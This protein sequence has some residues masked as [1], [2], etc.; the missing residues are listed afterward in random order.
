MSEFQYPSEGTRLAQV[1]RTP[2]PRPCPAVPLLYTTCLPI[3][4]LDQSEGAWL[5]L[6]HAHQLERYKL[7]EVDRPLF[8]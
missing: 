1:R 7:G 4:Y 8:T 2:C 3:A 5:D 6:A